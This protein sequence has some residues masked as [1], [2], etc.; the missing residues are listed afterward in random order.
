M[1]KRILALLLAV[2]L[3]VSCFALTACGGEETPKKDDEN[4]QQDPTTTPP[5][6][7]GEPTTTPGGDADVPP[8]LSL[9]DSEAIL[10]IGERNWDFTTKAFASGYDTLTFTSSDEAIA[11][12]TDAGLVE[13]VAEGTATI[14]IV[15]KKGTL[16]TSATLSITVKKP[17][18]PTE[19]IDIEIFDIMKNKQEYSTYDTYP[20]NVV[21][22]GGGKYNYDELETCT[23]GPVEVWSNTLQFLFKLNVSEVDATAGMDTP[24]TYDWAFDLY[25]K[26]YDEA[27]EDEGGYKKLTIQ[28]WSNYK[29]ED[30]GVIYRCKF[31]DTD[32]KN[33]EIG[34]YTLKIV[35]RQGENVMGWCSATNFAWTDSCVSYMH[36][37][38]NNA[39]VIK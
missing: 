26:P 1:T 5:P 10:I 4:T 7:T 25:Y 18:E 28:A 16:E 27:T 11:T 17:F 38:E 20:C 15:A 34:D 22:G 31:Y 2:L 36:Y 30:G 24:E 9:F 33:W 3:G 13:G 8:Q 23:P 29:F 6:T 21:T 37:A 39:D 35:V 12:V 19:P 32:M 14:T